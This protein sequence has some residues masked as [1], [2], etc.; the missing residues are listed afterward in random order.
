MHFRGPVEN[1]DFLMD[2]TKKTSEFKKRLPSE[3]AG[4]KKKKFKDLSTE[5]RVFFK[6][7]SRMCYGDFLKKFIGDIIRTF[8]KDH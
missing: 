3:I 2:L 7:L 8:F 6:M 1:C 4:L 5:N